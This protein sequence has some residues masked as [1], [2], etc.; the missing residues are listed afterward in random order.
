MAIRSALAI[1]SIVGVSARTVVVTG[2]TGRTGSLAYLSLKEQGHDVRAIVRNATKAKQRLGCSAC[3][4]TEG[5]FVGDVT[6]GDT[7]RRA[8]V[9]AESL[10]ITT[11]PGFHCKNETT[12]EGCEYYDG[13]DPKTMSWKAVKTQVSAFASSEGPA[14][15]QRHV[16]L[17]S[18]TMTTVP[19]NYLDQIGDGHGCFYALNGEAFVENSGLPFTIIKANGLDESDPMRKEILVGHDDQGWDPAD[20]SVAFISRGDVARLL[21]YAAS[22]P[23]L[24]A[25]MRFDV[26]SRTGQ[27]TTDVSAIFD[28]A[29]FPWDTRTA[30]V[31]Q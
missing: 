7:L 17:M 28:A 16:L 14:S 30:H 6:Q 23:Q 10:V 2:A 1:A 8:M 9:D 29:R 21:S 12:Y 15:G 18:N 25:A 27:A 11:G 31:S 19:N 22:N 20:Q 24:T 5:V 13:A 3:D 4:E 26:T